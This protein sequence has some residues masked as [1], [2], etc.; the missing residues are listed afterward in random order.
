MT[1]TQVQWGFQGAL[2]AVVLAGS[3]F[4]AE[5]DAAQ[6]NALR[7]C[8]SGAEEPFETCLDSLA[9]ACR[10]A[11]EGGETT[12]GL[13]FCNATETAAWDILLNEEYRA[14]RAWAEARDADERAYFPEFAN[15]ADALLEAQRAWIA[16]RD[17]ECGLAYAMWGS[18]S[19]RHIAGT[20][21]VLEMTARRTL[22]L[23]ALRGGML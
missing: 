6:V 12:L 22:E 5:P 8:I 13:T 18:G 19:M 10:A 3:A 9:A 4:A 7:A 15:L 2:L 17:A 11:Q 23:R 21:C 20:G 1:E 16:H 14:T